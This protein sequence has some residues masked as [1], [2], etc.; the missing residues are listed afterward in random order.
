MPP[1][2]CG[3]ILTLITD[4]KKWPHAF[5]NA[6]L[7][8]PSGRQSVLWSTT[9]SRLPRPNGAVCFPSRIAATMSVAR[10]ASRSSREKCLRERPHSA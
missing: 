1:P 5:E 3:I 7:C 8:G 4:V 9:V 6:L 10:V 2:S